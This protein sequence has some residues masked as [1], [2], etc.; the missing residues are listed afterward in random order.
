MLYTVIKATNR[1]YQIHTSKGN[2]T[3]LLYYDIIED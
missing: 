2:I 3:R 1:I